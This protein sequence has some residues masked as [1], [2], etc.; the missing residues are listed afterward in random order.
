MRVLKHCTTRWLSLERAVNRLLTLWPAL[1]AYFNREADTGNDCCK[2]IAEML[3]RSETKLYIS[4]VSFA[5][6]PLNTFNTAFQTTS[7]KIGTM[8]ADVHMLLRSFLANFIKPEV[9]HEAADLLS[10]CYDN[11]QLPS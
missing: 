7:T 6:K 8:Q 11:R 9:I 3:F 4:F 2:K 1:N 5:L 10:I